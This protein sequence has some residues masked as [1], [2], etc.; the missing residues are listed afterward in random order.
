[1]S[2][3]CVTGSFQP[4]GD[5]PVVFPGH[6]PEMVPEHMDDT[7]LDGCLWIERFYRLG[8]AF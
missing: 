1:M 7:Q 2:T 3:E 6:R 5:F 4:G 8:K